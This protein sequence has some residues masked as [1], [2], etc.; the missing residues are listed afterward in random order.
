M[1]VKFDAEDETKKWGIQ[2]QTKLILYHELL[3]L[4]ALIQADAMVL[5]QT[6]INSLDPGR[7]SYLKPLLIALIQADV[8]T[9]N[10]LAS[11]KYSLPSLV[12]A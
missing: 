6:T 10:L 4:I 11:S 7:W 1:P 12:R 3:I 9:S 5:P 8:P 2:V